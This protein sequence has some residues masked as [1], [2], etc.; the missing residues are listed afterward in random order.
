LESNA[1]REIPEDGL[2]KMEDDVISMMASLWGADHSYGF[3][4]AGATESN[5]L[6][7]FAARNQAKKKRGSVVVPDTSH[8][9]VIKGCELLGLEPIHT[10]AGEDGKADVEKIRDAVRKDTIAV[11]ATCGGGYGMVD[12]IE[13]IGRVAMEN[14][15]FFHVDAAYGGL[16]CPW[17]KKAGYKIPKFDFSVPGVCSI[18]GDPHKTGFALYPAG[19]IVFR[20]EELLKSSYFTYGG[21]EVGYASAGIL[22][23]RPGS[24]IAITW[25]LFNHLGSEGYVRISKKCMELTERFIEGVEA[26]PGLASAT[27][28]EINHPSVISLKL[29]MNPIKESLKRKGWVFFEANGSPRTRENS[30]VA[31]TVPYHE[32]VI[33]AFLADLQAAARNGVN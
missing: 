11:V 27:K 17:L 15:L 18:A 14:S 30:I 12:P 3:M 24:S 8:P 10:P 32:R 1:L 33:P 5:I 31:V 25:A 22:G 29:D 26:I 6:G 20:D 16:I 7:L 9:S 19:A 2:R 4:T 13:E 23:S 28:P 21:R